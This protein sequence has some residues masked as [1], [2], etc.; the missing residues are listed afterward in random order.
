MQKVREKVNKPVGK[1]IITAAFLGGCA[2]SREPV[3]VIKM[4]EDRIEIYNP[5]YRADWMKVLKKDGTEIKYLDGWSDNYVDRIEIKYPDGTKRTYKNKIGGRR[6]DKYES[7]FKTATS[8]WQRAYD[9]I[10]GKGEDS[11]KAE[12]D[13]V[14]KLIGWEQ[15]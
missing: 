3:E 11:T 7:L 2:R 6:M 15:K 14:L 12:I 4:D 10:R 13:S 8:Y 9:K 5:L 1:A